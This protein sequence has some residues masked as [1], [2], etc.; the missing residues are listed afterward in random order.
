MKTKS[1][2]YF[3]FIFQVSIAQVEVTINNSDDIPIK[4]KFTYSQFEISVPLQGNKNRG[5]VYPDGSVNDSWFIPDGVNANFGYGLHFN[6]WLGLSANIGI[7]MKISEKLIVAPI[8]SNL[9]I[10]PKVSDET[11]V[12]LDIGLG[13]S[14]AIGRGNLSG[15][16]KRI[17][18]NI[19]A[20]ELQIF[21]EV[22]SYGFDI[23]NTQKIGSISIGFAGIDIL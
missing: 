10:M 16:F 22:V 15:T 1:L 19:E 11:R 18:L 2:F 14:F 21:L 8:F 5:E 13:Q 6:K 23:H 7:G 3:L 17:K 9:R 12:G 4:K 20:S